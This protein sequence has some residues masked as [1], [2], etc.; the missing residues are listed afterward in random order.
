ML[1]SKKEKEKKVIAL[2]RQGKTTREIAKDAH[3]NLKTIE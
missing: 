3:V 1:L 2:A